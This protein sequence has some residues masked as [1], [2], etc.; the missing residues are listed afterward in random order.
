MFA[1]LT[2]LPESSW[3]NHVRRIAPITEVFLFP[4]VPRNFCAARLRLYL[5]GLY[6]GALPEVNVGLGPKTFVLFR[7]GF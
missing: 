6:S 7:K 3:D 5:D 4:E 2:S 1:M